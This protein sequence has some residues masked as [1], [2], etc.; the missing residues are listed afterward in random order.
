[1]T[2]PSEPQNR[3]KGI[4]RPQ[5]VND[6]RKFNKYTQPGTAMT[7]VKQSPIAVNYFLKKVSRA[8]RQPQI[9][10]IRLRDAGSL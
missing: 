10:A 8:L 1:M 4:I 3:S 6:L 2:M 9:S 5:K 7:C